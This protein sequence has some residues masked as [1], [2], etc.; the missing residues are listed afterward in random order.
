MAISRYVCKTDL[1]KNVDKYNRIAIVEIFIQ[2]V[3][4]RGN[5]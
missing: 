5:R 4:F 3:K 1:L 2:F